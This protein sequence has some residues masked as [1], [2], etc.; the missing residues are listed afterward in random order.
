MKNLKSTLS[1]KLEVVTANTEQFGKNFEQLESSLNKLS[2]KTIDK[3]ELALEVFKLRKNFENQLAE[4]VSD[5]N[6]RLESLQKEIDA[7]EIIS[8]TQKQTLPKTSQ[9][10]VSQKSGAASKT[11]AGSAALPA[12]PG[13]ITEKDL[14]E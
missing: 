13:T 5:L 14:I 2:G 8:G 7:V 12:Q 10:A 4:A 3:D 6:Q 9:K 11:G 1:K